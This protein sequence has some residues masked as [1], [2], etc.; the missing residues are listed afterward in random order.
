M[1]ACRWDQSL[2]G[3]W[4]T[5]PARLLLQLLSAGPTA[6]PILTADWPVTIVLNGTVGPCAELSRV[7]A[8]VLKNLPFQTPVTAP[9]RRGIGA[10]GGAVFSHTVT[11]APVA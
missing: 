7:A 10:S 6:A 9:R 3:G 4:T 8:L 2:V 11:D 5:A 1:R